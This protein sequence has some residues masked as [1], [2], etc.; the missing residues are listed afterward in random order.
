M[1]RVI[2]WEKN[3]DVL[4]ACFE[5]VTDLRH[6]NGCVSFRDEFETLSVGIFLSKYDV[7]V[8]SV[9]EESEDK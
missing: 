1:F 3:S 4:V 7:N 2:V 6:D 9:D 8:V 5:N